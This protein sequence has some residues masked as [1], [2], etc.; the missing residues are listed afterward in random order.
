MV[1]PVVG[2]LAVYDD[3][4]I[5]LFISRYMLVMEVEKIAIRPFMAWHLLECMGNAE[6]YGWERVL[7]FHAVRL[8]QLE[9]GRVMWAGEETKLK[10]R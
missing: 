1:H 9:Y 6:L 7:A 10:F 8:Q 4:S 3:I 5:V 2:L